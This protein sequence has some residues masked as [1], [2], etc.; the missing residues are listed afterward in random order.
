MP[1]SMTGSTRERRTERE[2]D[3]L[4]KLESVERGPWSQQLTSERLADAKAICRRDWAHFRES[5]AQ[6]P[7]DGHLQWLPHQLAL[8]VIRARKAKSSVESWVSVES[9]LAMPTLPQSMRAVFP[10]LDLG[11]RPR[12]LQQRFHKLGDLHG[13]ARGDQVEL[14]MGSLGERISSVE[15][16]IRNK[17]KP[18]TCVVTHTAS[19]SPLGRL[20][21]DLASLPYWVWRVLRVI[22]RGDPLPVDGLGRATGAMSRTY[23]AQLLKPADGRMTSS[24][25]PLWD[26]RSTSLLDR[27]KVDR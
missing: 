24:L 19:S 20:Q 18:G 13:I 23:E 4:K 5:K 3:L 2:K 14:H 22:D 8:K 25:M 27:S 1:K 21:P 12:A 11:R 17:I 10:E 9:G 15:Q 6:L 16:F 7:E 26:P